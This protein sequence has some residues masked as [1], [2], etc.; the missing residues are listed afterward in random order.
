MSLVKLHRPLAVIRTFEP[1]LALRSK[2]THG[3][4]LSAAAAAA[5][6][7]AAPAPI[8]ANFTLLGSSLMC[9]IIANMT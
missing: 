1:S 4:F 5:N 7:P 2:R 8:I 9:G 3:S 6:I